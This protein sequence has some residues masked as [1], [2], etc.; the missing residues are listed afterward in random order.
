MKKKPYSNNNE[1]SSAWHTPKDFVSWIPTY[2]FKTPRAVSNIVDD[3]ISAME[4]IP[5]WS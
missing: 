3:I 5:K 1:S 2:F 4:T